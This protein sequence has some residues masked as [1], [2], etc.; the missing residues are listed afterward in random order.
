MTREIS[1]AE[2]RSKHGIV[3]CHGQME[4][5][6]FRF[7]LRNKRDGTAY[8]LT[9]ASASGGWQRSH[10]HTRLLETYVVQSD[11]MALA[12][13]IDGRL[14]V[15]TFGPGEVV[16]TRPGIVHNVYLP[17]DAVIH[18]VK[19]GEAPGEDRAVD[20]TTAAFDLL[21]RELASEDRIR[22]AAMRSPAKVAYS[23]EYRHFDNLIWQ[24]PAWA[25]AIFA[26]SIQVCQDLVVDPAA[27]AVPPSG[28]SV[29]L[30]MLL[31]FMGVA[32]GCFSFVLVRFR[33]H[34]QGLKGYSATPRWRSAST[35]M[36]SLTTT[37]SLILIGIVAWSLGMP[38]VWAAGI[39]LVL[40]A[41]LIGLAERSVQ[42]GSTRP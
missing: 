5:D 19:H 18:T 28:N 41:L 2:A 21:T 22:A 17:A 8:V 25:T 30:L 37:E 10:F 23:E 4:N 33:C 11:W 35:I 40:L 36:Q 13:L 31:L 27:G 20:S 38:P 24:V 39:G 3:T 14:S 15:R 42:N 12:E 32:I 6:E 34:Q 7:R 1:P 9:R 16:T 29:A 26:I